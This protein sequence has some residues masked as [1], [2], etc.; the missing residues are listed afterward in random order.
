MHNNKLKDLLLGST[1]LIGTSF[2]VTNTAFAQDAEQ[3]NVPAEETVEEDRDEVVVTGSRLKRDTFNSISPLQVIDAEIAADQGLF[4]PVEILQTSTTAAGTQIDSTFQGFVLDNGPGSETID[5]RGLGASRTLVLLNGRRMAPAGVEGAPT[6]PS[7]NLIPRTLVDRFDLLTDGASSVY[8][9][10]AVA[11]VTNVI[12]KNDFDGLEID[13]AADTP[14]SGAGQDYTLGAAWGKTLDRG[15]F[16]FGAEYNFQDPWTLA[17][18]E[19]LNGCETFREITEDGEIRTVDI[20]NQFVANELGLNTQTSECRATRLTQRYAGVPGFGSIYLTP[21]QGNT[22]IGDF[23]RPILFSVPLDQNADGNVDAEFFQFSPNGQQNEQ[24]QIVNEQKQISLMAVGEYTLEG[25]ANITPFFEILHSEIA[26]EAQGAQGQFFPTVPAN[27]A[28]NPCNVNQPNGQDCSAAYNAVLTSPEYLDIFSRY[29]NNET[30]SGTPNCFGLGTQFCSPANFGLLL[31]TGASSSLVPVV[32]VRGDRS[33]FEVDIKQ[34]RFV[35]GV[36]G[37]LPFINSGT[38]K[39]WSF[40][41]SVAHSYSEGLSSREGIREDRL[42]LALGINPNTGAAL[43]APCADAS[44][45]AP[46]VSAG[47]VPVNLFAPSLYTSAN[48]GDFAS[49]AE[50]DYLFDSRDF[51]TNT[52]QTVIDL[53]L[54]GD[55]FELPGGTVS[56]LLGAQF[57]NDGI[58]SRPDDIARDGLFFGFFSDGGATGDRDTKELYAET[59]LPLGTGKPL[60]RE[61]TVDLAGRITDDEF[62]GTNETF[63]IKAGYRPVDSLL[64]R[65]TFGTSFRAPNLRELFLAGQSGFANVFDPCAVPDA[66]FNPVVGGFDPTNDPRSQVTLDN[67]RAFGIDPTT[68]RAGQPAVYS[69]EAL[70]GGSRDLLPE[71]S[72]SYTLGFSFEQPFT[73]AFDLEMGASYYDIDIS[74]T[75]IEPGANFIVN[76]CFTGQPNLGSAFC[77]RVSREVNDD[78]SL[79]L[80]DIINTDFLNRNQETARGVDFNVDLGKRDV[81]LFNRSFDFGL[82]ITGNHLLERKTVDIVDGVRDEEEFRGDFGFSKWQGRATARVDMDRWRWSWTALFQSGVET[83]EEDRAVTDFE[84]FVTGSTVTCGGPTQGDVNCRPVFFANDYTVHSTSV[85]YSG[86]DWG[87]LIGVNNVFDKA[88]PLVS[89]REVF[90]VTNVPIGNGYDLNGREYFVRVTKAFR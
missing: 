54:Q 55:V 25:D 21:G 83:D 69:V 29:Y 30:L 32:G 67:C 4:S 40:D 18:R 80:I 64:L 14:E 49:Q 37:D 51:V 62:Y 19:F 9:S 89:P 38:I 60:F 16:G 68:F 77:S 75:I 12:L 13:I 17:D 22:G 50:R 36:R 10:D 45:F 84:N 39:D 47:C 23:T 59:S 63:S 61:F 24:Q 73:T 33:R 87:L 76:D 65:G 79:G 74:D 6:Q 35:G 52:D 78:G 46:S 43:S 57:R 42:N 90:S 85:R 58:D 53:S 3:I 1:L 81:A 88:P 82:N 31:P 86:D 28:F 11:G 72:D 66:A 15:Y 27:N 20:S 2:G 34:T 56:V 41:F 26:V 48:L 70:G 5:L 7:I 44:N 8:G 71:T